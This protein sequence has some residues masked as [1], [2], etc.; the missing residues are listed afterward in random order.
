MTDSDDLFSEINTAIL[1]LQASGLQNFHRP[2]KR[3]AQLLHH[4]DLRAVNQQLT[5]IVDV[6]AFLQVS[7]Q[8]GGS[9]VGSQKL[10][11]PDNIKEQ[12]GLFLGVVDKLAADEN[13]AIQFANH[14][15]YSGSQIIGGIRAM[16]RDL[17]IPFAREYKQY[18]LS[19]G[20]SDERLVI[21]ASNKVFIVH[22]HD[23]AALQG[24]ARFLEKL[25]LE[26]IVLREQPDKGRTII[27]KFEG[28]ADEVGFAVVLLTPDDIGGIAVQGSQSARTRQNVIFEL[29]YF[30]GKLGRGKVCLLRKGVV[31][32][33]SDLFGVIYTEMDDASGW[34]QKLVGELKAAKLEF[35][36]NRFWQ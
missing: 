32:I 27:E 4:Q 26:A 16:T 36:P 29:G 35:D 15:F 31:E 10:L 20:Q 17:I 18:V 1:D 30:T 34:K 22:G 7:Y 8:T 2:I 33:P 6:D 9:M 14:F 28:S 24:L 5:A 21:P 23:E 12:L 11:W 19:G 13:F 3:L 25:G